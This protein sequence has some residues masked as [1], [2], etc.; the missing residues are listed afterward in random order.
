MT[1]EQIARA[2]HEVLRAHNLAHGDDSLPPWEEA[3]DW[4]HAASLEAVAFHK[5]NPNASPSETH[6]AW[7]AEK[8]A[9]G[10]RYGSVK[11]ADARTHPML[12]DYKDLPPH[13]RAKDYIAAA[14]VRALVTT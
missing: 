2:L 7:M 10:W 5:A 12:V 14:I 6:E 1:D 13:E 4:Q 8:R 9:G 11:D 3:H